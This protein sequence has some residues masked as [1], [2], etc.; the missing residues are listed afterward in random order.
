MHNILKCGVPANLALAPALGAL[1]FLSF[2]PTSEVTICKHAVTRREHTQQGK[3]SKPARAGLEYQLHSHDYLV[4]GRC[5]LLPKM[6]RTLLTSQK[7]EHDINMSRGLQKPLRAAP[8]VL[9]GLQDLSSCLADVRKVTHQGRGQASLFPA[10]PSVCQQNKL[11]VLTKHNGEAWGA[12]TLNVLH[13]E[14]L[15]TGEAFRLYVVSRKPFPL[16]TES[17]MPCD[18]QMF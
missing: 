17:K 5:F 2:P 10:T 15:R 18:K 14:G 11:F 6:R 7:C 4:L 12:P 8:G 1:R 13:T 3:S 9:L 16:N